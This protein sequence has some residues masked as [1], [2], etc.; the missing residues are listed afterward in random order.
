MR[1][2]FRYSILPP[3][4]RPHLM[5]AADL[6]PPTDHRALLRANSGE[7]GDRDQCLPL[8]RLG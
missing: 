6:I 5:H 4:A 2:A 1:R 8:F 7:R 3:R